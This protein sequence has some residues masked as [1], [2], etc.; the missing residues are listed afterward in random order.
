MSHDLT[1]L[2]GPAI[3]TY[4]RAQA[5]E[6]GALREVPA[7]LS[8]EAGFRYPVALTSAAWSDAVAWNE[9]NAGLQDET[10]RLWDVLT[11]ARHTLAKTPPW[12]DRAL[13]DVLRVPNTPRAHSP[14]LTTL[15]VHFGPGDNAE[16]VLTILM[17]DED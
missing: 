14:R 10:G 17:P 12:E 2:F 1:D 11:M 15:R 8:R 16:S 9:A 6:D 13:F 4:T 7:D 3:H 5:I